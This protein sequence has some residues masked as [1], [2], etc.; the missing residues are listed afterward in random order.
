MN[1]PDI[2]EA[3]KVRLEDVDGVRPFAYPP[4]SISPGQGDV[5]I[6]APAPQLI[7]YHEAFNGGLADFKLTLE[8]WVQMT[9]ERSAFGRIYSLLSS[10]TGEPRSIIDVLMSGDRTYGGVCSHVV[11]EDASNV[12]AEN[13]AEGAR[14][15]TAEIGCHVLVGRT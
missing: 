15:L 6:I 3:I 1:L 4:D 10:G 12:R 9:S 5:V 14:Y 11:V 2:V 7:E 8:V 13:T